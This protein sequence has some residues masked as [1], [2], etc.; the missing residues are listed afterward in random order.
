[1]F[2]SSLRS[3]VESILTLLFHPIEEGGSRS[4]VT[5]AVPWFPVAFLRGRASSKHIFDDPLGGS[6]FNCP[7][8]DCCIS[9]D[10][11]RMQTVLY[12]RLRQSL[13]EDPGSFWVSG[14]VTR[15]PC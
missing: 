9:M 12:H 2:R 6:R 13:H 1:M 5:G 8:F 10:W 14:C 3:V 7:L 4:L 15:T 11:W